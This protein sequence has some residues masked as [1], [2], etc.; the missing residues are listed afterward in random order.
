MLLML[1]LQQ[2]KKETDIC[3]EKINYVSKNIDVLIKNTKNEMQEQQ[4]YNNFI[5]SYNDM[6]LEMKKSEINIL[7]IKNNIELLNTTN[8]IR[9][10]DV[11]GNKYYFILFS[12]K[13]N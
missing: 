7:E 4:I 12:Y 6:I 2:K 10:N 8:P 9:T 3:T 11:T 13:I 1:S 5:K